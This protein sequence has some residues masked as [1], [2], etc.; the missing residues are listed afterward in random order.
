MH[1]G[2]F[3]QIIDFRRREGVAVRRWGGW[4]YVGY[5][6][7]IPRRKARAHLRIQ[8]HGGGSEDGKRSG[9]DRWRDENT[10]SW[11]T[12]GWDRAKLITVR[13]PIIFGAISCKYVAIQRVQSFV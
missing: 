9:L 7:I 1:G 4:L 5:G 6:E 3:G 13:Q 12:F 2:R 11:P 8:V 10:M